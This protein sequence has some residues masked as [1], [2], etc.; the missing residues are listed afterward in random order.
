VWLGGEADRCL[1]TS[2]PSLLRGYFEA[3]SRAFD[4]LLA[5]M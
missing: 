3:G 2:S 5:C 1:S 4:L